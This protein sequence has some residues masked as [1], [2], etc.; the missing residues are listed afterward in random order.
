MYKSI[1]A[2]AIG[3]ILVCSAVQSAP[4]QTHSVS[5]VAISAKDGYALQW[6]FPDAAVRLYRPGLVIVLRPGERS[7]LV[8]DH[9]EFAD[10]APR[11]ANGDLYI[12]PSLAQRLAHLAAGSRIATSRTSYAPSQSVQQPSASGPITMQAQPQ[13]GSE[14]IA[15]NGQAPSEAPVTITLLATISSDLPTVVVSRNIVQPDV[16]RN[17]QA[18]IPIAS[19]YERGTLLRVLATSAAGSTPASATFIVGPPNGGVAVPLEAEPQTP[20]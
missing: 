5:T 18:V 3:A 6:L 13:P 2:F 4:A 12:S 19:A 16:N 10:L 11:Y 20:R 9:L 1:P 8:N 7:Y 15:V 14:A 17:F